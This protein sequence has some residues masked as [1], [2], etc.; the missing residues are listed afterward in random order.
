MIFR[1]LAAYDQGFTLVELVMVIVIVGILAAVAIPK[2]V[3]LTDEANTAKCD[4]NRGT[5]TS[6]VSMIYTTIV[7]AD[8]TQNDWLE[9]VSIADLHDSMFASGSIPVCPISTGTYSFSYGLVSCT[10][11]AP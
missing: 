4:A 7:I 9:N 2:M 6:T 10:V 8:P 3:N 5:I 11:H 1:C